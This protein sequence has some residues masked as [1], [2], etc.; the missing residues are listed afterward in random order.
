TVEE[1]LPILAGD[2]D[3]LPRS[4][5]PCREPLLRPREDR[6]GLVGSGWGRG[7]GAGAV[8]LLGL[9]EAVV[10]VEER[11]VRVRRMARKEAPRP[12]LAEGQLGIEPREQARAAPQMDLQIG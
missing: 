4:M 8:E 9:E 12:G 6:A 1:R 2:R 7:E 3:L 11:H 10:E 5:S